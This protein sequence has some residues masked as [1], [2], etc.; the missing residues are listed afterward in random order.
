M[1][2]DLKEQQ[3]NIQIK[4]QLVTTSVRQVFENPTS[5]RME[6]T[7]LFPIPKDAQVQ[8]FSMEVN[9]ELVEAELLD[10]KKAR[11][12]YEDIVRQALDPA[13]FEYAGREL[14]KV[15]IFP[16][17]PH[18]EKEVRITYTELLS[19]DENVVRFAYPLN[20]TKY[21]LKPIKNFSM[22][23]EM[24]ASEGKMLKTVYSPS[25]EIEV[26]RK[27][28][29]KAVLGLE[30]SKMDVDQD[31]VL[32]YS[33]KP[34]GDEP[35]ALDFLTHHE[36]GA[37]EP[38]HFM[39]L[40]SP[41]LWDGEAKILPKDVVFVFDSSGSMRGEKMEQ[42][43][44]AL[45][46]CIKNLNPE[47]RFEVVRFSTEAEA[48]FD[49]MVTANEDNLGKALKFV[50]NV[51]A[52]GG[53]AIQEALNMA[54]STAAEKAED[55]RPVQ[56]IFMTDG[57]PTL[58]ATREDVILKSLEKAM[59]EKDKDM[60]V[61]CFGIGTD[62]NTH[63]L[64][65]VTERTRAVS[66]YVLPDEDIE[67][68]V[69][70]FYAK[71]SEP[72][73]TD[74]KI[75]IEGADFI[76]N[77]YP[78]DLPDIFRGDQ[79]LVLGRY[80]T[81]KAEGKVLVS[82]WMNGEKKDFEFPVSLGGEKSDHK[83]I[84]HL[85]ATRRVGYLLDQVRL[86]GESNELREEIAQLA[87]KYGIVTPYTSYLIMEDEAM[88]GVP[89]RLRT[90]DTSTF[91]RVHGG[92]GV[93]ATEAPAADAIEEDYEALRSKS[94][95]ASAVAGAKATGELKN[96]TTG[97][98]STRKAN[99]EADKARGYAIGGAQNQNIA[100]KTFY[101]K[102]GDIWIDS[103]AQGLDGDSDAREIKF[104]SDEYFDLLAENAELTQW[105]SVGPDVDVVVNRQLIKVRR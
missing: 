15:R 86:E 81:E 49:E 94:D 105:L 31:F 65:M 52:I 78:K 45:K 96:A 89:Q 26:V 8:D 83:F 36:D 37:D 25:H 75:K 34:Q 57:K 68:K 44:A 95:G 1:P 102:G 41:T 33:L 30:T 53:T 10:A 20:T 87:R 66:Q 47:D 79:L 16:I 90:Q 67:D 92:S 14:F 39:M 73:L 104:G 74:L 71:I 99:I 32:Y 21:C 24:E 19:K 13:L 103:E 72:V 58:G 46:Y 60:R 82:G 7:F 29:R 40:L 2:L 4:D 77:R 84:A 9:G 11:K 100:G 98:A 91:G 93:A 38:G 70:R 62:I 61:F 23:I 22:K 59:G 101:Q 35:I 76:R 56:I 43:Q 64:D 5:R 48:V 17:E 18:S 54:V 85:W 55:G 80:A 51:R 6:G 3:V 27:G 42:A 63:L 97:V 12:I 28:K 88:R 50:K 69:S